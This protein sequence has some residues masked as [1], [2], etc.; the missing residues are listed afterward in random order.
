MAYIGVSPSNGVR[1]KHTYTAT[2][3]QTSFSG[4]GAEGATL[5]YNDS[6]FVDVYQNGVK[7]S[8]ADYTSTSGTAI[9]LAQG[10]SVSDMV[11]IVVYDVFS[12]ADTVSKADGGTFDGN[13]T[14]AG[15]IT[16]TGNADLNGDLD[17][18]GTT[19]LDV[20]DIDG[21]LNVAGETTL[22]T[23]LNMGDND[24]IKIGASGDLEI[25]HDG[26][27]SYIQD[28]GS[29][30]IRID[31]NGTDVRITKSDAEYMGKFITDG[32]VELYHNNSKKFETTSTG[33]TVTGAITASSG[34]VTITDG[35]LVVASGHGINF[36]ATGQAGGMSSELLSDYEEGT[37]T[38]TFSGNITFGNKINLT[39]TKIG[40]IVH[41]TGYMSS[42]NGTFGTSFA[43]YGLPFTS[44][45]NYN[46]APLWSHGRDQMYMGY[47]P[48]GQ[49][50][51][52]I[53]DRDDDTIN[54]S[55]LSVQMTYITS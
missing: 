22:Q 25:Y 30:E 8:E 4:A 42:P 33:V 23:H 16:V 29:G 21:T 55:E 47:I 28:V 36:A 14:M 49:T 48:G 37:W 13:V 50:T 40:R 10:A 19:N 15:T 7:L 34:D 44:N 17:V 5:S 45:A 26:T 43:I 41:I 2:A 39:Y 1:R 9:V 54:M 31:T 18:D 32:A 27:R 46:M 11:E 53:R 12:V 38:A 51:L 52:N 6:N 20:V 3:N 35:N 24:K